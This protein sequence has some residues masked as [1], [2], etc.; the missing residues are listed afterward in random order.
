MLES[1][2]RLPKKQG[3]AAPGAMTQELA[4]SIANLRR[5]VALGRPRRGIPGAQA[6]RLV[7]RLLGP[8]GDR[9]A[10]SRNCLP[11]NKRKRARYRAVLLDEFQDTSPP[12]LDSFSQFVPG[13]PVMAVGDPNQ[14]IYGFRG[15]SAAALRR[16][17]SEFG[18]AG[19]RGTR[20]ALCVLAQRP[21]DPRRRQRRGRAAALRRAAS[22]VGEA[23]RR[24]ARAVGRAGAR[25]R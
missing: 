19:S 3:D 24:A 7:P 17:S 5:L 13:H 22:I 1:F 25:R 8:G 2:A 23:L 21:G 20:F 14:A 6:A 12:Q 9:R 10:N 16:S 18:G 4:A 11:S 15:A